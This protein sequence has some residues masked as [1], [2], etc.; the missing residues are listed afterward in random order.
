MVKPTALGGV[1]HRDRAADGT[2]MEQLDEPLCLLRR[3][4]CGPILSFAHGSAHADDVRIESEECVR[5]LE[6]ERARQGDPEACVLRLANELLD[7]EVIFKET[8]EGIFGKR[9]F[10][11]DTPQSEESKIATS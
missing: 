9:P 2:S 8:L 1:L 6:L 4:C 11:K 5:M 3:N 10:E 7:K